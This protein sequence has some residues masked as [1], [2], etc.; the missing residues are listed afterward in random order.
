MKLSRSAGITLLIIVNIAIDQITKVLVRANISDSPRE[1]IE[2]IGQKF[3]LTNVANKGAFLGIGSDLNDTL[4][5]LLLWILP[6]IVLS[7][8]T[9]YI[10]KTKSLDKWSLIAFCCIIG[11]GAANVFD[12]IAFGEVTDFFHIDLGG[13]FKTGIFNLADMSVTIG[14]VILILSS[15]MSRKKPSEAAA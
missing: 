3:I 5:I 8:V 15:F 11:G 9:Y 12:R 7:Y 10:F 1:E 2:L 14:M 13:V 6:I 4:R